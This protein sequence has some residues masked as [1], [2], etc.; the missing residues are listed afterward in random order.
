MGKFQKREKNGK[1][2]GEVPTNAAYPCFEY[3]RRK[4]PSTIRLDRKTAVPRIALLAG[5][6]E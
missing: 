1:M 4:T 6:R 3:L 5:L 2:F